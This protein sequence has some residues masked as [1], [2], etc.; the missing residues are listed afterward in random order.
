MPD[1]STVIDKRRARE[2]WLRRISPRRE[3]ICRCA[4]ICLRWLNPQDFHQSFA[5]H[6][7]E[8]DCRSG[9]YIERLDMSYK[10]Y[11]NCSSQSLSTSFEIP[12]SSEPITSV[13]GCRKQH[14]I[15]LRLFSVAATIWKPS[16]CNCIR[17]VRIEFTRLTGIDDRAQ[18]RSS[19]PRITGAEFF[20]G[21]MSPCAPAHSALRAIPP[22]L[23]TR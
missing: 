15:S 10:G 2:A 22:K 14:Q 18:P 5:H 3:S 23:R 6:F 21:V 8:H 12:L 11:A 4:V 17:V 9:R 13:G 16:P 20:S 1:V 19:S 7:E